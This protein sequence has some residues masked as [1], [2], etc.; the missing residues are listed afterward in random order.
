MALELIYTWLVFNK[1]NILGE[2]GIVLCILLGK[3]FFQTKGALRGS[4]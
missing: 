2:K 1:L 3:G 4:S